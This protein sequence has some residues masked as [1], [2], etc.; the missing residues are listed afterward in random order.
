MRVLWITHDVIETFYPFVK[1][2]P[3]KGASWSEPLF[4]SLVNC[5]G[6]EMG[7][8]TPVIEGKYEKIIIENIS[9]Y[10]LPIKKGD[11]KILLKKEL[12][13]E[14]LKAI[15]DFKPDIIHVHGTENNFGLLRNHLHYKIPIVCSIQGIITSCIPYITTSVANINL[16]KYKSLKN[17]LGNGGIESLL[18]WWNKSSLIEK[19]IFKT[20]TYFFG[21]TLWD[22]TQ[23]FGL[24]PNALYFQGE[25]LLR[26]EFYNHSWDINTCERKSIFFSSGANPIKGLH[27]MLK[28]VE[29]LKLKHPNIKVNV[30]L[31]SIN[32]KTTL[33]DYLFGEDYLIYIRKLVRK[34][35]LE[36]NVV[37]LERLS[38]NQMALKFKNSHV[39]VLASYIENSPN[40]LGEAMKIGTPTVVSAVGGTFS[41]V[42]DE[43]STLL[44]PSGDHF[45][46]AYQLDLLFLNDDLANKLS[47]N[48]KKIAEKRH[49]VQLVTN[50]Y[51]ENYKNII[52]INNQDI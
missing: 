47:L 4:S 6:L 40:S 43:L 23:L 14:Y 13:K 10:S 30:P 39:F 48:A 18:T 34:L 27:V 32:T 26:R 41:M 46:L 12:I 52:K 21:R 49:N 28:A 25:E 7:I 44:F 50:Q 19:E 31:A 3:S 24:N 42:K 1:G 8:I 5:D 2:K 37:F 11:N 15:N 20:N 33:R 35:G 38:P 16:N 45:Y 29:I 17:W 9:M 22:K 36:K 51:Y